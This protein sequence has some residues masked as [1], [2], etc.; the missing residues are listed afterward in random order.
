MGRQLELLGVAL[1]RD[2]ELY[3]QP[4]LLEAEVV[5]LWA[6]CQVLRSIEVDP[7]LLG[8]LDRHIVSSDVDLIQIGA[9]AEH[10][11]LSFPEEALH[12]LRVQL[13]GDVLI[14]R[15]HGLLGSEA[16]HGRGQA[17]RAIHE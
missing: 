3:V 7:L 17:Q 1:W 6:K 2:A 12:I 4:L 15:C 8:V 11:P 10:L 16:L 13:V 5:D 9:I 14:L